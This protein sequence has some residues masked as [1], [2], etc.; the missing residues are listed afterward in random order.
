MILTEREE[1]PDVLELEAVRQTTP[2]N[3][4]TEV[5]SGDGSTGSLSI[6]FMD[7]FLPTHRWRSLT[8]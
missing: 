8:R 3:T 5:P 2:I 4:G 7:G 6:G 1:S